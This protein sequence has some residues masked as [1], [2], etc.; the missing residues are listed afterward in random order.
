[1][2][3]LRKRFLD[4]AKLDMAE[5]EA[6]GEQFCE[7]QRD[8]MFYLGDLARYCEHK[9]PE[10]YHQVFPEWV[11]PGLLARAAG[12]CRAYPNEADRQHECTYS[13]FMQVAGKPNRQAL[14]AETEGLTTD[15]SRKKA[16][17]T[18]APD[19]DRPR[20]LLAVDCNYYLHRWWHSG[21]GVEAAG[22]VAGW[23]ERTA[24]RLKEEK[25]LTDLACCFDSKINHRKELTTE[26]EDK[27]K[28]RAKKEPE[29]INQINLL[30]ELLNKAGF[31]TVS[32]DGMEA[33]DLMASYAKQFAGNVTLLTQDKDQR[34]CL[35]SKCNILLDVKWQEDETTGDMKPDYQWLS[36]KQHLDETGIL[37]ERWT[38]YQ[39]IMG[40]NVDGITGVK[41]IGKKGAADI[42]QAF[43]NAQAVIEAAKKEDARLKPKQR[44][45]LIEFEDRLEV[46]RQ[47]VTLRDDLSVP[48]NTRI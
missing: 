27:Y 38:E 5:A 21:A 16:Q 7:I 6:L 18:P 42:I 33:D 31:A 35:S 1:M 32:L 40:D 23:I 17:A 24:N 12:V 22:G 19:D 8:I 20:W 44:T 30:R 48:G 43:G 39:I 25:G 34:Q 45:A 46:T 2:T 4:T 28:D 26:W 37:P 15:D 47:L 14:L 11:S 41:G 9:W 13:Q 10:T 36:A 29:L 3:Q